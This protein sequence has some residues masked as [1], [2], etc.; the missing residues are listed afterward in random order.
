MAYSAA[1]GMPLWQLYK[2]STAKESSAGIV[3]ADQ[4]H[5]RMRENALLLIHGRSARSGRLM[6][7]EV[8]LERGTLRGGLERLDAAGA[9]GKTLRIKTPSSEIQR[10]GSEAQVEV[11][12]Q[13]TAVVAVYD[14]AAQ[15]TAQ[16]KRVEVPT[17]F[18]TLVQLKKIPLPPIPLPK[19]PVW[20]SS[21]N[22]VALAP[23]PTLGR[24]RVQWKKHLR[25]VR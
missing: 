25:A 21:G 19:P 17:D 24:F 22:I 11:T 5:L 7:T 3:F 8:T 10:T 6:K 20:S 13:K 14:G 1:A 23:A 4:S 16:G 18:G 9:K 2:V 15:V 12:P